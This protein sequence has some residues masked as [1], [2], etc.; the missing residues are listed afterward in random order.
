MLKI[1][2]AVFANRKQSRKP[3]SVGIKNETAAHFRL[4]VSLRM[5]IRV[6]EQGQCISEKSITLTAVTQVQPLADSSAYSSVRLS[7]SRML[8]CE[9]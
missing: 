9:R 8:P 3:V 4:P 1:S 7:S 2:H 5:V 6:V